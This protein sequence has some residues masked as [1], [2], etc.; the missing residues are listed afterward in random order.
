MQLFPRDSH[1]FSR[2]QVFHPA[3]NLIVPSVLD[4]F[5]LALKLSSSVLAN[6]ARS[7]AERATARFR[8]SE[9]SGL[10]RHFYMWRT[11]RDVNLYGR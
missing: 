9:T 4:G 10:I 8:R 1:C 7:S 2:F 6:A 5:T 3:R 11:L